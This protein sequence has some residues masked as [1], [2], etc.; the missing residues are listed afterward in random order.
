MVFMPVGDCPAQWYNQNI[1]DSSHTVLSPTVQDVLICNS[2]EE[3][4][5]KFQ[6]Y[7]NP[8][9]QNQNTRLP[10]NV[11]SWRK[12]IRLPQGEQSHLGCLRFN[13]GEPGVFIFFEH[14]LESGVN[15]KA[16]AGSVVNGRD[17]VI[18]T[19]AATGRQSSSQ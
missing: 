8:P 12:A 10:C 14:A 16:V 18:L 6:Y 7:W 15:T 19:Q 13:I 3:R 5:K 1:V 17:H 2:K 9:Y 4:M 11:A